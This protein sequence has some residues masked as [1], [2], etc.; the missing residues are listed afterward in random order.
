MNLKAGYPFSLIR[1]GLVAEY[2]KL[3]KN[4]NTEVAVLGGGISGALTAWHLTQQ[5]IPTVVIDARSIGLGSTCASTSLL[6]YEIDTRLFELI[7]K[8]GEKDA[9]RAYWLCNKAIKSLMRIADKIGFKDI[10]FTQSLYYAAAK[11]H[12][13]DLQK[14]FTARKRHGFEVRYLNGANVVRT[15]GI[16]SPAAILS[17]SAAKTDAYLFTHHLHQHAIKKGLQVYDR[18]PVKKIKHKRTGVE[19]ITENGSCIKAKKLV[20]A[21]GYEVVEQI[22]KPIVQLQS[23]YAVVSEPLSMKKPFW[24]GDMLL[25]NTADPYLYMRTHDNRIIVG[26]RD[27]KFYSPH[28][29]DALIAE[30]TKKLVKDFNKVFPGINFIPEFSWTGTFGSTKDGLPFI[31]PYKKLPNSYFALGFGGNGITFSLIAAEIITD[32]VKGKKNKDARLFSFDRI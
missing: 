25:W 3:G 24:K 30:K 11:K 9:V 17:D 31:G 21:T 5:N 22:D 28:K 7:E 16:Q 2:P 6:Q 19:L 12:V 1:N 13:I 23:T 14:E 4:L 32:L 29:R 26:G 27:E 10:A 18:S 8:I 20:Y 15:A